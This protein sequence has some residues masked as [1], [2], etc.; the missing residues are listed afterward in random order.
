[1]VAESTVTVV[2]SGFS[3]EVSHRPTVIRSSTGAGPGRWRAPRGD[4]QEVV[5][6]HVSDAGVCSAEGGRGRSQPVNPER[7]H[8]EHTS[9]EPVR[10]PHRTPG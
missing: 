6:R 3:A 8:A 4:G 5:G 1:M 2:R 10:R 9:A 7:V